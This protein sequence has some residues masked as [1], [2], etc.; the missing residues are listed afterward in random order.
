MF[1]R[2]INIFILKKLF[3]F[4]LLDFSS[5]N[6]QCYALLLSFLDFRVES[7]KTGCFSPKISRKE[8]VRRSLRLKFSLGKSSR[9]VLNTVLLI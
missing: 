4:K 7:G 5:K 3:V 2:I 8:I 9:E 6:T 1:K